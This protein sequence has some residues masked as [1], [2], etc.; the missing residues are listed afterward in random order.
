[1]KN[2]TQ[3][4]VYTAFKIDEPLDSEAG[5]WGS[6]TL[7]VEDKELWTTWDPGTEKLDMILALA[8]LTR[9]FFLRSDPRRIAVRLLS[10]F[11]Q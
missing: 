9:S 4:L 7:M 1:M 2:R 10:L 8:H 11:S 3:M 5:L 6:C